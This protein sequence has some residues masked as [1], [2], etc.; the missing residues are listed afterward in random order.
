MSPSVPRERLVLYAM[1]TALTAISIDA[2]LPGLRAMGS[3]L[4]VAPPLSTQHVV[5]LFVLGMVFGELFAGPVSDA[6]GRKRVLAMGLCVYG[7]GTLVALFAS[8]L[9]GVILGRVLQGVGVAG[10]KIA[11]RAM[12]RDQF[13]GEATARVLSLLFSIFILVPMIAPVLGQGVIAV[14]G[15]RAMFLVYLVLALLLGTWLA[16][17][18]PET[19]PPERRVALRPRALLANGGRILAHRRV[20]LLIAATGFVFGAQL[21]YLGLAAD[22]FADVYGIR[23][24][25]PLYFALLA[26]GIGLASY[27]NARLVGRFGTDAMARAGFAGL[28]L[29]GLA[30]LAA[31]V[32]SDGRPPL[33]SLLACGFA[34]FFAIGIL[35]GN[36]NAMAMRSLGEVAGLGAS[37]IASGSSL[38]AT[39][40][41]IGLGALYDGTVTVLAGGLFLAGAIS[42]LLGELSFRESDAPIAAVR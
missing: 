31:S 14:A 21:L 42:L 5:S 9:E 25:F 24:T 41:A 10:P 39:V 30:L 34:A 33:V 4:G 12:I 38:V 20:A 7:I 26:A 35:F 28:T 37:L 22:L 19:L 27:L 13:E 40:F 17:R 15:W 1:L 16:L 23:E 29:A 6:I 8:S 32:A 3:E 36:L 2:L 11:T 18:Q